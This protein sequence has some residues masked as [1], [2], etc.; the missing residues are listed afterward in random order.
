[1]QTATYGLNTRCRFL[2]GKKIIS[3]IQENFTDNEKRDIFK[4]HSF[5]RKED[6]ETSGEN[7]ECACTS[8]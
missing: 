1:V 5:N 7:Q 8:E 6:L 3:N 4:R 2:E